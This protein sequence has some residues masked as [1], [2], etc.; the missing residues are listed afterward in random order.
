MS[1]NYK[2]QKSGG[3]IFLALRL[4]NWIDDTGGKGLLDIVLI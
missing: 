1:R 2:I 3:S 4:L